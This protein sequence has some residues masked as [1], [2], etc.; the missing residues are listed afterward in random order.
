MTFKREI[1]LLGIDDGPF[2]KFKDKKVIVI[3]TV[4]RGGE[5]MDAVLSTKVSVDG[6]D[7]TKKLAAMVT[8]AKHFPQLQAILLNGIA[9]G[10]FNIVD[11]PLLHQLTKLPVIAVIRNYPDFAKMYRTM[12]KLGWARK[13][14]LVEQLPK[15]A[16][17]GKV[18]I[19][20]VGI[21]FDHAAEIVR[22]ASKHANVPEP[23]RV[24]HIIAAGVVKGES[25]GRA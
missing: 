13:I 2:D 16:R 6:S 18:Y 14:R 3:G 22:L 25:R 17:A 10:G 11:L 24:A 5:F 19:Q 23:L 21:D 9:V 1:R 4:Y 8:K 20:P 12:K 7:S 15:P